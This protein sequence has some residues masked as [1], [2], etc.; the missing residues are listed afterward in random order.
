[1]TK[2]AVRSFDLFD[3]LVARRCVH[4]FNIFFFVERRS[5]HDGFAKMHVL[6]ERKV[7]DQDYDLLTIYR[8]MQAMD[9]IDSERLAALM[10]MELEEEFA[11][12]IPIRENCQL[13]TPGDLL[14][15]DMYLPIPFLLRVVKQKC[16]L[17]FNQIY[18]TTHGKSRGTAWSTLSNKFAI[19]LHLGDNP[20]SD[21]FMPEKHGIPAR[22]T[23]LSKL[24]ETEQY[25]T[26]SG[27][28]PLAW[29]VR[30]GDRIP[31]NWTILCYD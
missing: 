2:V 9:T 24:T 3:T 20:H 28:E 8:A 21:I 18:L 29:A 27:F 6:A 25:L 4:P 13:V 7:S 14:V 30:T 15:S 11:N 23:E 12:L 17:K 10:K 19:S 5:S 16:G 22:L 1:M 26:D 31:S